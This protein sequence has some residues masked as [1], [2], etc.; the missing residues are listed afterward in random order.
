MFERTSVIMLVSLMIVVSSGLLVVPD[1]HAQSDSGSD[2]SDSTSAE[3]LVCTDTGDPSKGF[4]ELVS[5]IMNLAITVG[6]LVGVGGAGIYTALQGAKPGGGGGDSGYDKKR[7]DSVKYGFG[8]LVFVYGAD[9]VLGT[10]NPNLS[11][12]CTLPGVG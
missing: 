8:S 5:R 1:A 9:A 11:F 6:A 10:L 7:N 2:S 4:G 3:S 12:T